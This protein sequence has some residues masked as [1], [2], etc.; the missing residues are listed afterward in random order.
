MAIN[1]GALSIEKFDLTAPYCLDMGD[2]DLMT[3]PDGN[4]VAVTN[5]NGSSATYEPAGSFNGQGCVKFVPP[6]PGDLATGLGNFN[7][8]PG[9]VGS[10]MNM[11]YLIYWGHDMVQSGVKLN[12]FN[13]GVSVRPMVI[14]REMLDGQNSTAGFD[15][16]IPIPSENVN[17]APTIRDPGYPN[18]PS[19]CIAG[20]GVTVE[21]GNYAHQ[22]AC[23]EMEIITGASPILN[24]YIHTRDGVVTFGQGNPY[25][26][27]AWTSGV[28]DLIRAAVGWYWG[29]VW[30]QTPETYIKLSDVAISNSYIGTP[31]GFLQGAIDMAFP[32]S[33]GAKKALANVFV[34]VQN[35]AAAIKAKCVDLNTRAA[36]GS[37]SAKE[38]YELSTSLADAR[39][40]FTAAQAV[41]GIGPFAQEQCNDLTLNIATEFTDMTAALDSLRT[42]IYNQFPKDASNYLLCISFDAN[43]R[44]VYRQL[45]PAQTATIRTSLT[46]FMATI[47]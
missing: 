45:T 28:L 8:Q 20:A 33:T 24:L 38:F 22:W 17:E 36:A 31:A 10:Q 15:Y 40:I 5:G 27:H 14:S 43:G 32:S 47:N 23:F 4:P 44:Y 16:L 46:A 39:D 2:A 13:D 26:T 7:F 18:N 1:C 34:G 25:A 21:Q 9:S 3:Y 37:V 19:F 30:S 41:P 12:I 29:P 35:T 42:A 11:R 6:N